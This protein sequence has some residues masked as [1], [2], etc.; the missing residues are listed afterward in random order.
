MEPNITPSTV[1]TQNDSPLFGG[2]GQPSSLPFPNP[3]VGLRPFKTEES[4]LFFGRNE[5]TIEL[6]QRLHQTRFLAVVGSS[7]CGKSSL[8]RA[9]LIPKLKAGFLIEER[10]RWLT[11]TM[12]PGDAPL[13][14]LARSLLEA[15]F[16]DATE[17][18][19]E[20]FVKQIGQSGADAVITRLAPALSD[21][22]SNLLL[23]I[24]QF[25]EIFRFG[26][27]SGNAEQRDEAEDFVALMLA[28][29]AQP[30][31]PIYVVLTMRSDF[32]GDCDNFYGLPE[33]M[34]RSQYLVPRL[35]RRQRQQ[36]IEGPIRLFG[37]TISPRLL[38]R[39][40][41]DVGD[42]SDQLPVMQ[43]A[44]MRTWEEWKR[45]GETRG[46]GDGEMGGKGNGENLQLVDVRHYE[47]VGTLTDAL[48]RD[49]E[50][51]L[52]ALSEEDRKIAE[53]MF[54]AL[55]DTDAR[56]RQI[57][58]R[59][60]LSELC[61]ITEASRET[62]E[63]IFKEFSGNGR[64]FLTATKGADPLIDISHESLI[65]QWRQ[66]S[67]WVKTETDWRDH[68]KRLSHDAEI[69]RQS[70]KPEDLLKGSQLTSAL[71]W[72]EKRNPNPAWA[73]RYSPDLEAEVADQRFDAAVNFLA[74][75]RDE[76][77]RE[78]QRRE[79]EEK[80]AEERRR[81][82]LRRTRSV[83]AVIGVA[84]LLAALAA[85]FAWRQ[86]RRAVE[87]EK[88]AQEQGRTA[89]QLYY[90]ANMNLAQE[91]FEKKN[92]SRG[93]E[94]LNAFLPVTDT[95]D[96][97]AVREFTWYHRWF[98][99]H[100][101]LATLKG[102][103]DSVNSVAFAPDGKTLASASDDKTVKLWDARSGQN[104]ATLKGHE[105]YVWSVAFAPDGKTLASASDDKTVKLWDARSGQNLATLTGHESDVGSVAFA[106]DGKT[107]ASASS[108]Q[109]VKLWD[110][111]SG[112]N[113]ATLKGHESF[114]LSVAFAPDGK[115]L[116]SASYDKT[117]KLW[118]ARSG[119]NL[120]TLK[121]HESYVWSVAFAPDDKTLASAGGDDYG[122]K[123]FSIRLWRAATDEEVARQRNR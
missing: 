121:G 117:V 64:S 102:H 108:D 44:L 13:Q 112:Q 17:P 95:Q 35:T 11:A 78:I 103:E 99:N 6:L 109:T 5:Q 65:R 70:G 87:Q 10:D 101:E 90:A 16:K 74:E 39:V 76:R 113:L 80:E 93:Y 110:A 84:F 106:P 31:L 69:H 62:I 22:S 51:A 57:R 20:E 45:D 34:N 19:I 91:A 67:D 42:K 92:S 58:R 36:A 12:K 66:A 73:R 120:A 4:L 32:I 25:E 111:R 60:H 18:A 97:S 119:Q 50:A 72:Q 118:D 3:F 54:Q 114:V 122:K 27:E 68:Y 15:A 21:S 1:L 48:S 38:D 85:W 107:L 79:Q 53:R 94:L 37:A 56:N 29:A 71:E 30:N 8:I 23:L 28:L 55:T 61:A 41:N 104:L 2:A 81:R 59:A 96:R 63:T 123:D 86:Q 115:T 77:E 82:E 52:A 43:H 49:A 116:A 47:A 75:S 14:N 33:A 40:L 9:G 26:V 83:A 98:Q 46:Q 7:G 88:I 105:S 89:G 100:Q 24:D